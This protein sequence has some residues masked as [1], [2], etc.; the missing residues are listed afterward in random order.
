VLL[1]GDILS[2]KEMVARGLKIKEICRKHKALFFVGSR[3]DIA[4]AVDADGVHLGPDDVS[5]DLAKQILGP[6][7][8]VGA[9]GSSLGQL[10]AASEQGAAYLMLGPVFGAVKSAGAPGLDLIRLVK[11]R[12]KAPVI[13]SGEI[14]LENLPQVLSEG[15]DGV[16]VSKAVCGEQ[17]PKEAAQKF[18]KII[19]GAGLKGAP[20]ENV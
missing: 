19:A 13:V 10:V 7:K 11:K 6:R 12:A 15:V 9:Y 16:A 18:L 4:L 14:T 2:P 20:A 8:L 17:S 5:I 3:P 1:G